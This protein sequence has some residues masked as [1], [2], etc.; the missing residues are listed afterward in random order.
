MR[1]APTG[2]IHGRTNQPSNTRR[3]GGPSIHGPMPVARTAPSDHNRHKCQQASIGVGADCVRLVF[4]CL[5]EPSDHGR[6][7]TDLCWG[8]LR[9]GPHLGAQDI[10]ESLRRRRLV[11]VGVQ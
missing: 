6:W 5:D 4:V 10:E 8:F 1:A 3:T 11:E 2:R 9:I 7:L